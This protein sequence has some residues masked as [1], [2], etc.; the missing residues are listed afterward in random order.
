[1]AKCL[2]DVLLPDDVAETLR[3]I[4]SCNYLIRHSA[5]DLRFKIYDV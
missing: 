4:F 1:V 3:A 2:R 5:L